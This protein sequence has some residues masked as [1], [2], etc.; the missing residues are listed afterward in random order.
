MNNV[1]VCSGS[2]GDVKDQKGE[3]EGGDRVHVGHVGF[4]HK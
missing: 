1:E 2:R 4:I 3:G